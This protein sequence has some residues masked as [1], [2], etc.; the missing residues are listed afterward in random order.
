MRFCFHFLGRHTASL[1]LRLH[2]ALHAALHF[3]ISSFMLLNAPTFYIHS[4]QEIRGNKQQKTWD[5]LFRAGGSK[6]QLLLLSLLMLLQLSCLLLLLCTSVPPQRGSMPA[7]LDLFLLCI[8][9]ICNHSP[10]PYDPCRC[11]PL[12]MTK[13]RTNANNFI[14]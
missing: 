7:A 11:C 6:A 12:D 8:A 1:Q 5:C 9:S 2:Q 10:F 13:N 3:L 4:Q 14:L